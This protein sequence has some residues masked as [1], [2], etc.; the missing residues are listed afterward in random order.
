MRQVNLFA[1]VS[2]SLRQH[3]SHSTLFR[4]FILR[5]ATT[6]FHLSL[7]Q[8][9]ELLKTEWPYV[10]GAYNTLFGSF[11]LPLSA[12]PTELTKFKSVL[13]MWILQYGSY[14]AGSQQWTEVIAVFNSALEWDKLLGWAG[15]TPGISYKGTRHT[16]PTY[17]KMSAAV[18]TVLNSHSTVC[19]ASACGF[20][21]E[22]ALAKPGSTCATP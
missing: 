6:G 5:D 12:T 13:W 14:F 1:T 21:A 11:V 18:L 4:E 10:Q 16:F 8:C 9:Y 20:Q 3:V 15:T 7:A 2:R 22:C 19:D 17:V